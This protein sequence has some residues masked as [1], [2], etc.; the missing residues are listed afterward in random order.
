[1]PHSQVRRRFVQL[2]QIFSLYTLHYSQKAAAP[3]SVHA[4]APARGQGGHQVRAVR[5]QH[6]VPGAHASQCKDDHSGQGMSQL[7]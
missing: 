3:V 1:M 6:H 5:G 4:A 7:D 2:D